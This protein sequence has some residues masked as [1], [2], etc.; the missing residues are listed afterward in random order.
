MAEGDTI[1]RLARR[2]DREFAGARVSAS[3]PGPR[4]PAGLPVKSIDG[5]T[6]E[7]AE[8][9]GKHLLLH[10]Q[11]GIALATERL[12]AVNFGGSTVRIVREAELRR[13]PK[14]AR[15]GPDLLA[16]DFDATEV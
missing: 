16:K 15:L 2:I 7:R 3:T 12:E 6:L 13:D 5:E 1:L 14:L 10:F 9:R 11:G 4:R 8:S